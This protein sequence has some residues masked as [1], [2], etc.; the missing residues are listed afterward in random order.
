M[1]PVLSDERPPLVVGHIPRYNPTKIIETDLTEKVNGDANGKVNGFQ[2]PS[3][4]AED[5]R[6]VPRSLSQSIAATKAV[7]RKVGDSGLRVSNP[8]LGTLGFG[9]SR[10]L[11]WCI[12]EEEVGCNYRLT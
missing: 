2:R 3:V 10:W 1:A 6:I 9:D 8:I 5:A 12:E 11:P 4:F 7:Y